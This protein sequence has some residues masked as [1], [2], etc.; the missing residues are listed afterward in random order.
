VSRIR[1]TIGQTFGNSSGDAVRYRSVPKRSP[2]NWGIKQ[3]YDLIT[4]FLHGLLK[5]KYRYSRQTGADMMVA[6]EIEL[7][8]VSRAFRQRVRRFGRPEQR[9][10]SHRLSH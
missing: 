7:S 5:K 8:Y 1:L 3:S 10:P 9:L 6:R 2:A 4:I